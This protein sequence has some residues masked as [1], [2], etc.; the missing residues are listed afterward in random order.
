MDAVHDGPNKETKNGLK[1]GQT[2][3]TLYL[4]RHAKSSWADGGLKDKDRPLNPRGI[5]SCQLIAGVLQ[6][7]GIN[8]DRILVSSARRTQETFEKISQFVSF[9]ARPHIDTELYMADAGTLMRYLTALE[10]RFMS[11]LLIGHNPAL[12]DL[13]L[14]LA[15][16]GRTGD[17]ERLESKFPT[18]ALAEIQFE[19]KH[20][21]DVGISDGI[22]THFDLP[23]ILRRQAKR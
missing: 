7:R 13:A 4:L 15:H 6:T 5:K 22:L 1:T 19:M 8:P 21:R 3:R 20:W 16:K 2:V 12:Q 11:V 9:K 10:D 18:A 23:K 14:I 17:L